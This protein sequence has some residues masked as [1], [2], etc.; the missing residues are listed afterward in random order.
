[1][2]LSYELSMMFSVCLFVGG[3]GG[4]GWGG[5]GGETVVTLCE[6]SVGQSSRA[7]CQLLV[8]TP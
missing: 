7:A 6:V 4:G 3:G 5:G 2:K 8:S 1:M